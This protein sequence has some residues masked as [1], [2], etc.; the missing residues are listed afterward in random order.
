MKCGSTPL[1]TMRLGIDSRLPTA[2]KPAGKSGQSTALQTGVNLR[3]LV[4]TERAQ[5]LSITSDDEHS[6]LVFLSLRCVY[7]RP[8]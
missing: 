7:I 1:L 3:H 6:T 2:I 8:K 4:L 5:S